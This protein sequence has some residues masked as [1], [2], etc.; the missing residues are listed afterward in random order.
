[1]LH[2]HAGGVN[3]SRSDSAPDLPPATHQCLRHTCTPLQ[4]CPGFDKRYHG[5]YQHGANF[6]AEVLPGIKTLY[7]CCQ[8]CLS[9]SPAGAPAGSTC[10]ML[11]M[12]NISNGACI[13]AW[14]PTPAY[15]CT[16][17]SFDVWDF[18]RG[19][20]RCPGD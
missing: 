1:M 17:N 11:S 20:A 3:H 10:H 13:I 19:N 8:A 7:E 16:A 12:G 15:Q 18:T 5:T 14:F 9:R 4:A 6:R 2:T